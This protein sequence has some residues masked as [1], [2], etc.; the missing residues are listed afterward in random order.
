[1]IAR[2]RRLQELVARQLDLFESETELLDEA[3]EADAAWTSARAD[4]SEELY[5]D[6]QLVVDAI[7][8][9]LHDIRETYAATLDENTAAEYRAAFDR[10]ARRRFGRYASFLE[11]EQ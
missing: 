8:E 7:G 11:G 9:A 5:G 10:A 1:M 3:A 6:Y 2:R 4:E